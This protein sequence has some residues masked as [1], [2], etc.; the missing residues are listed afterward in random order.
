[1]DFQPT[2]FRTLF[3]S[4]WI[5]FKL[6]NAIQAK[7]YQQYDGLWSRVERGPEAYQTYQNRNRFQLKTLSPATINN[8]SYFTFSIK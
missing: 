2:G 6:E 8:L 5:I 3:Q 4:N 7:D 1:M